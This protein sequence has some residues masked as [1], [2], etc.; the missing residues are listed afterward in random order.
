MEES[1]QLHAA[2]ALPTTKELPHS[3]GWE[4]GWTPGPLSTLWRRE[5]F[6]DPAGIKPRFLCS[7]ARSLVAVQ[8]ELPHFVG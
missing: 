8:T 7:S 6:R 1:G 2:A 4:A 3:I 5:I